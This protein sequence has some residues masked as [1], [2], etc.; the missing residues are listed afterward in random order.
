M[1]VCAPHAWSTQ[2]SQKKASNLLELELL[3]VCE[4]LCENQSQASP[5]A[6]QPMQLATEHLYSLQTTSEPKTCLPSAI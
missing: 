2:E 4:L 1:H 6:E 5:L 3:M